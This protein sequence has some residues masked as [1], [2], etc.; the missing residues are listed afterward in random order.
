MPEIANAFHRA[1][2]TYRVVNGLLGLSYTPEISLTKEVT[3]HRPEAVKAWQTMKEWVDA[4]TVKRNLL[5]AR[6]GFLG[7]TY[8][9]MLDLYSDFTMFQ[10]QTGTHIQVLEMCDLERHLE[11]VTEREIKEK[12]AEIENFFMISDDVAADPLAQKPT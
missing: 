4:A 12:R 6:F 5:G 2:I 8:S 9:G 7:N 11:A 10:G 3:N 1:G